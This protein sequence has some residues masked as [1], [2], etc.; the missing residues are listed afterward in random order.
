MIRDSQFYNNGAGVVPNTLTS[1]P[2]QPADMGIIEDNQIFWNNFD[3]YR[4]TSP[5]QTVSSGVGTHGPAT[6][7]APA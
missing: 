4:K 3:Y 2:D 1:E 7:S 6:R 5:V